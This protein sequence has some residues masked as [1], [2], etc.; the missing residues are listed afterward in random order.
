MVIWDSD[1]DSFSPQRTKCCD[2][3]S[4]N[5]KTK[6]KIKGLS[7][8]RV[9]TSSKRHQ[10]NDNLI[11]SSLILSCRVHLT[12]G[13]SFLKV[14]LRGMFC[15]GS[16]FKRRPSPIH[17]VGDTLSVSEVIL[18]MLHFSLISNIHIPLSNRNLCFQEQWFLSIL[19]L[20][21]DCCM[22]YIQHLSHVWSYI[23]KEYFIWVIPPCKLW[24]VLLVCLSC[25]WFIFSNC[26]CDNC[27]IDSFLS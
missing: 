27:F 19:F 3:Y 7:V 20:I 5:Y 10:W 25:L 24:A 9:R 26:F 15:V 6:G 2:T 13:L 18:Q 4:R 23:I 8:W 21:K 14:D 16:K 11:S 17:L 1:R 22:I 12:V